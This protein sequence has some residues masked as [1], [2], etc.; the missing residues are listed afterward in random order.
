MELSNESTAGQKGV[1][2]PV[3]I[4]LRSVVRAGNGPIQYSGTRRFHGMRREVATKPRRSV[5][6]TGCNRPGEYGIGA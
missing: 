1:S 5:T 6:E 3:R 2:G 4:E